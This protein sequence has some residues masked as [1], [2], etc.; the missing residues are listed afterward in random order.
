MEKYIYVS[1]QFVGFHYWENCPR[2]YEYLG[3]THRHLFKVRLGMRVI[4]SDREIE[5]HDLQNQLNVYLKRHWADREFECSCEHI[6]EYIMA[7]FTAAF[8]EVSE[9]GENGAILEN[10]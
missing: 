5:F 7:F 2:G 10:S 4:D 8:V 3:N 9:D 6:A 1:A